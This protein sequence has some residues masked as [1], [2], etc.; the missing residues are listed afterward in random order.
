MSSTPT[1]TSTPT[2]I[3]ADFI[4]YDGIKDFHVTT[5]Y[6]ND[7]PGDINIIVTRLDTLNP[8]EGWDEN[9][10]IFICDELGNTLQI[11]VGP[12]KISKQVTKVTLPSEFHPALKRM[13]T[14]EASPE[15][16]APF[17][18]YRH[19]DYLSL[20][21]FNK[22]FDTDIVVLPSTIFAVGI[23]DGKP[24]K[25]HDSYGGYPWTYE[26]DLTINYILSVAFC[27]NPRPDNFYFLI[28]AHDGYM[29]GYYPSIRTIGH[30][31]ENPH[32]YL[33]KAVVHV[34][35]EN[36]FPLLHKN[37]LVLGQCVHPDTSHVLAVPDRYYLC[38]NRYNL[39]HSI[40]RGILFKDK[41]S[42]IVFACNP[43]G[44][45]YNFTTRRDIDMNPR[46]YFKSDAV[47]KDTNIHAPAQIERSEM[48]KYKYIMDIDGNA[49][50]WDATAWKLNSGSIIFKSDSNWVQW[51]YAEYL[52]WVHYIP[53]KDD[54]SDIQE[55]FAWCEEN[56]DKCEEMIKQCKQLFKRIYSRKNVV[57]YTA[58]MLLE[59][60]L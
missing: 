12:S 25:H 20:E 27:M 29:E 36:E 3:E 57:D 39:Y 31:H 52:A 18:A 21:A 38:L 43:R 45:K 44:N 41:K 55:K 28:C 59:K 26:I 5:E 7:G 13:D 35:S 11:C 10:Q 46:D 49:S 2:N 23:K 47:P 6:L 19:I 58:R 9:L 16:Y 42:Q 50:T 37:K 17:P 4:D 60:I 54:F 48:I 30:K 40:H 14:T 34:E 51:F 53:I 8:T 33:G 56:P 32:E 24:Y 15:I 1:S 22:L